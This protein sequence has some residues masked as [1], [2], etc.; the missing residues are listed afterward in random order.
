M[1]QSDE[2]MD[3]FLK[4]DA[5]K[6]I[7]K[8]S[9][10]YNRRNIVLYGAGLYT[11][12]LLSNFDFSGLNIIGIADK[13]FDNEYKESEFMG[14]KTFS[15]TD[16]INS[17]VDV[18]LVTVLEYTYLKEIIVNT[19]IS[20]IKNRKIEIQPIFQKKLKNKISEVMSII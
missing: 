13:R 6:Q 14:Y 7:D 1:K 4:N 11:L 17:E 9:K 20:K 16:V 2:F 18:I 10:K 19:I 3:L 15:P 12:T 5:Q 8:M